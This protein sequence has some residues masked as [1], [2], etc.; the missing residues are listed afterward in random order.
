MRKNQRLC[1]YI[2][3]PAFLLLGASC[4][5]PKPEIRD[6]PTDIAATPKA[7]NVDVK[8]LAADIDPECKMSLAEGVNDTATVNGKRYG[9][10]S[11]GC[12]KSYIAENTPKD[13]TTK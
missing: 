5:Q 9:F 7:L 4:S 13:S 10:C 11:E 6:V 2:L 1:L 8:T 3:I 12:K